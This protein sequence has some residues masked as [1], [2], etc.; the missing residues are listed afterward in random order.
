MSGHFNVS[1]ALSLGKKPAVSIDY[2]VESAPDS[3]QTLWSRIK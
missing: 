1:A 3:V 2:K